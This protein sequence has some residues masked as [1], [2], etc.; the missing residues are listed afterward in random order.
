MS[1]SN[2]TEMPL[3]SHL[4]EL[5]TR[6]LRSVLVI[7]IIFIAL[8]AF[9]NELYQWLSQPL[10]EQLPENSTLI[11]TDVTAPLFAP[12]KLAFVA[13]VFIAMPFVLH[14]AWLFISPGL[15]KHEKSF[16]IPLLISSII[17]FYAGIA[18]AYFIIFPIIFGF[19]S[20]I[21]PEGVNYLPDI[22]SVLSIALKLFF[23]FGLAFEIPIAT[24]LLIWSGLVSH[25]KLANTRPYMVVGIFIFAMLLTPP[26]M[27]SQILLA[28]PMWILFELGLI[29]AKAYSP[30]KANDSEYNEDTETENS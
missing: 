5:R 30:K 21:G 1:D 13:S 2:S 7:V 11:A 19:L 16:A 8:A 3:L 25:E 14:Q 4:I 27:I 28:I 18:F 24:M 26:D 9:A 17:L 10:V 12:F 29:F 6:L 15:Y 22:N 20:S 23:A